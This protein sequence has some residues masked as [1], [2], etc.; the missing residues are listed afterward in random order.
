MCKSRHLHQTTGM[1]AQNQTLILNPINL[2]CDDGIIGQLFLKI[3]QNDLTI[4]LILNST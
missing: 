1:I 2:N 3:K 4:P